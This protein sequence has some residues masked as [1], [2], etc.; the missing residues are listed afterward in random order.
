MRKYGGPALTE[1]GVD[2][3]ALQRTFAEQMEGILKEP[4]PVGIEERPP[5]ILE[6]IVETIFGDKD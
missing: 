4:Y 5:T 3:R 1:M 2:A 6:S